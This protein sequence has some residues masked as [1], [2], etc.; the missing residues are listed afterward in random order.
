MQFRFYAY[1]LASLG[2]LRTHL[3]LVARFQ[4]APEVELQPIVEKTDKIDRMIEKLM[5]PDLED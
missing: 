1:A 2:M 5:M 3:E 4:Y